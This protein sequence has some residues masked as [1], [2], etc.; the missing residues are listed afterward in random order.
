MLGSE[1]VGGVRNGNKPRVLCGSRLQVKLPQSGSSGTVAGTARPKRAM[2]APSGQAVNCPRG[3]AGRV[4]KLSPGQ[5]SP[6]RMS[7]FLPG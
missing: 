1:R 4:C 7:A 2:L 3:G 5:W 6:R